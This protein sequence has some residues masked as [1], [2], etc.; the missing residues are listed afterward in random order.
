MDK[1]TTWTRCLT[2]S[3]TWQKLAE[4]GEESE[5][6]VY[7]DG[8]PMLQKTRS[9][10]KNGISEAINEGRNSIG[11]LLVSVIEWDKWRK[12]ASRQVHLR[13]SGH[14]FCS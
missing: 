6:L 11:I 2:D 12:V 4:T 5:V 14:R 13:C 8:L 1:A 3:F 10:S 7:D 9:Q